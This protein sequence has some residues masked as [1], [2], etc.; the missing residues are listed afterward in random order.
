[1]PLK[2]QQMSAKYCKKSSMTVCTVFLW[3]TMKPT[4]TRF[5]FCVALIP[6]IISVMFIM[7]LLQCMLLTFQAAVAGKHSTPMSYS[8]SHVSSKQSA[9]AEGDTIPVDPYFT[10]GVQQVWHEDGRLLFEQTFGYMSRTYNVKMS[11]DNHFRVGSNT[12]L[13]TAVSIYQLYERGLLD[14]HDN[15]SDYLDQSDFE[16]FGFPNQTE[17]C[18]TVFGGDGSCQPITF[19]QLMSMR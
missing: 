12:K 13:F 9:F 7:L 15:V 1:M 5:V 17:W 16:K 19:V 18:P 3:W 11:A 4:T 6:R 14:V 2:I 10:N 8:P